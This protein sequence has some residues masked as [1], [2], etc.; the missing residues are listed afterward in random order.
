MSNALIN[1][2]SGP[3]VHPRSSLIPRLLLGM[4]LHGLGGA[5]P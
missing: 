4:R 5:V 2:E 1:Y 3:P